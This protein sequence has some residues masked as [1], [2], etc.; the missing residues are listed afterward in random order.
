MPSY[1]LAA[2]IFFAA[3][4]VPA[5][6]AAHVPPAAAQGSLTAG[7][8]TDCVP[9]TT[10]LVFEGGY[11][12]SLC[13]ET[14]EGQVG[15]AQAG[16]WAS[17]QA[18]LL[19]FFDRD[20]AE[21]LVKVLDGCS[22]NGRRWVF[23]AP[24]TD[25]AFN[26]Q[27]TS[28]GGSR[29]THRNRLGAT[30][31]TRG[32]TAAFDCATEDDRSPRAT[33]AIPSQTVVAD[34]AAYVPPAASQGSLTAGE[35]T[36]CVPATTPL[37]FGG[38]YGV[39][40]CYETAEGQVG[41]AQAGIW[42]S[43]QA[44]L[45]WFFDRDNAEVLVKVLDGCAHNGGRWVFVAPVTDVAFNLHVSSSGGSRW[46]HR[47]RLGATAATRSDTAAFDCATEDDRSPRAT[48]AIPPQTVMVG[49][50]I[51][52]DMLAYFSDPDG[53]DLTYAAESSNA[54]VSAVRV[55][56]SLVSVSALASGVAVITATA[57]D[58]GGLSARQAFE[59]RARA[60]AA[61][62]ILRVDPAV[63]VEGETAMISGWGF[64]TS[65]E[66][67]DVLVD[68]ISAAV[69]SS[70]A[71]RLSITVPRADCLPPRE[72]RLR[73]FNAGGRHAVRVG[74]TPVRGEH[75][76]WQQFEWRHTPAGE[77]C[78]HLPRSADGGEFLI[79]VTSVSE[80]PSR[81]TSVTLAGTPGDDLMAGAS[82]GASA[83][84]VGSGDGL[85]ERSS[86]GLAF[87]PAPHAPSAVNR[88]WRAVPEL[89]DMR[90]A[91]WRA[92][93]EG[94]M[95]RNQT[96]L[97][98]LGQAEWSAGSSPTVVARSSLSAGDRATLNVPGQPGVEVE[99]VVRL[100]GEH[101]VW[102]DDVANPAET[103]TDAELME[104]DAFYASHVKPVHDAY[105]GRLSDVD[106]NGRLLVLMTVELNR[107]GYRGQVNF[108]DLY[109][110][111]QCGVSNEAEIFYSFVPDPD[112]VAG[113]V[114]PKEFVRQ[115]FPS[116]LTHEVTH[117]V[118]AAASVFGEAS[119]EPWELEGGA[120]MAQELVGHRLFGHASVSAR[121]RAGS[122][123]FFHW[124]PD[125]PLP[126]TSFRVE[127][128]DDGPVFIWAI[129]VR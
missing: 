77:G 9:A 14:A 1:P 4:F 11:G 119:L 24:V 49:G 99:A 83:R 10:P 45:L 15:E 18:G 101:T 6:G 110:R 42:A 22:H 86:A 81:L 102:L 63:L 72:V 64:S 54:A 47:N 61:P 41:E 115:W 44:G 62:T 31:A 88:A 39:S 75:L 69:L 85:Q 74:L 40:L 35:Y 28:S 97:A 127:P 73:V 36:D 80:D 52:V 94:A 91:V 55:E 29:W 100:V 95:A 46:T 82:R 70:S 27:V 32:D 38:G 7:E 104:L 118:Q 71:T 107:R 8:Y 67:N 92:A 125:G 124:T 19:W 25:V 128:A 114:F 109:R 48:G 57:S 129:R 120:V 21:V 13:Y 79:G 12:V 37:G 17:G 76:N 117:L 87:P 126:P 66:E 122:S 58:P 23:V 106:G 89:A 59:V 111:S 98:G 51:T 30:A 16:I 56:D 108:C 50:T 103:F 3:L 123:M 113:E 93:H 33:G 2:V 53:D 60:E 90:Q 43:G 105:F 65:P 68:G 5:D 121:I 78:I 84:G 96:L 26:L 20:N 34:G 112:G 116:L